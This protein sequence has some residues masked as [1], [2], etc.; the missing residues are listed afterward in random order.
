MTTLKKPPS[1]FRQL[2]SPYDVVKEAEMLASV[3]ASLLRGRVE[4]VLVEEAPDRVSVWRN[5]WVE[6]PD[7]TL[8]P[9]KI[10]GGAGK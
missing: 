8:T 1:G 6:L 2:T 9:T 4:F 7:P 10:R 3:I 5:N